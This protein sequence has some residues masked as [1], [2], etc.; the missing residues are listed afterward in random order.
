VA[1]FVALLGLSWMVRLTP[2]ARFE[3][4]SVVQIE[5]Q[6]CNS[7][8]AVKWPAEDMTLQSYERLI[9]PIREKIYNR[10][11]ILQRQG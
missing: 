8:P 10:A 3:C 7:I 6:E 9:W 2:S 5:L 1:Y 11:K 4:W